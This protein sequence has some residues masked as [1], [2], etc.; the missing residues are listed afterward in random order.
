MKRAGRRSVPRRQSAPVT[1]SLAPGSATLLA[2]AS[3]ATPGQRPI[4]LDV[5]GRHIKLDATEAM[6]LRDAAASRA[7]K[8][9]VARD[10]S[11]L[12]DRA[13]YRHQVIALRRAEA[14]TLAQLAHQVGLPAL[15]REITAPAA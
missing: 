3:D 2:D 6:Q 14:H 4:V 15:M 8:S 9:S 11:L 1:L 13:L 12:L 5:G 10:L 7:G